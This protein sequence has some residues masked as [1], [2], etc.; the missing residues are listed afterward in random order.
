MPSIL[1]SRLAMF[2]LMGAFLIP[3]G[4]SSLRGL[5]HVLTCQEQEE[6]PFS[7]L[8]PKSGKPIITTSTR[9]VRGG[10]KAE[11]DACPGLS[12]DMRARVL[13]EGRVAMIL[14]IT[15]NT[16]FLWRGTVKLVLGKTSIPVDI[17]E[18]EAGETATDT[19][20]FPL[21]PGT[22]QV[23]GSLLIGP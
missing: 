20:E 11:P 9:I 21:K 12:L 17:G 6:N 23:S 19:I 4:M 16:R 3:I 5:T 18:I 10:P 22:Q 13:D 15:N 7:L 1:R 2:A 8:L 14:P